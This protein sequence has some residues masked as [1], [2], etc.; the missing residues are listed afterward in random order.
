MLKRSRSY[1]E[2]QLYAEEEVIALIV[3]ANLNQRQYKLIYNQANQ[4]H[5]DLYPYYYIAGKAKELCYPTNNC[6]V[7]TKT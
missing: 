4:N 6:M 5:A 7:F 2:I 3:E 1:N